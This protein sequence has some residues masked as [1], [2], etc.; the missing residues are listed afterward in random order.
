MGAPIKNMFIDMNGNILIKLEQDCCIH[1]D[2]QTGTG[3]TGDTAVH[4]AQGSVKQW[5]VCKADHAH[6][7]AATCQSMLLVYN[8]KGCI[9][10][11][12]ILPIRIMLLVYNNN[13]S[14]VWHLF[15]E[16]VC[17]PRCLKKINKIK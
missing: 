3:G 4:A 8:N 5:F 15:A 12:L 14:M 2:V 7:H 6:A 13:S 16:A 1:T 10:W 9:F 17:M 11:H